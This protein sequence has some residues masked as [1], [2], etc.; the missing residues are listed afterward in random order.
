MI[1]KE[2]ILLDFGALTQGERTCMLIDD[3]KD[4][5]HNDVKEHVRIFK[6][7]RDDCED[8]DMCNLLEWL[9]IVGGITPVDQPIDMI[10]GKMLKSF[11]MNNYDALIMDSPIRNGHP[12]APSRQLYS[13]L[14]FN[15]WNKIT[16]KLLKNLWDM[17]Q[18][19]RMEDVSRETY[20]A[21][22]SVRKI[23]S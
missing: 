13:Q 7:G 14:R 18:C 5:I 8:G 17:A 3:F 11:F 16:A 22:I 15:T 23:A 9:T 2:A 20:A 1:L 12:A 4:H 10:I 21:E 6:S 19:K